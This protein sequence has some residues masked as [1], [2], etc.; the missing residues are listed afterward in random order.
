[1]YCTR[2][3][4]HN[5]GTNKFC[6]GCG[7]LLRN[8]TASVAPRLN[9]GLIAGIGAGTLVVVV[10]LA[11]VFLSSTTSTTNSPQAVVEAFYRAVIAGEY[12]KAKALTTPK[13]AEF[14]DSRP[15]LYW[16]VYTSDDDFSSKNGRMISATVTRVEQ[17]GE[18]A[19][20]CVRRAFETGYT[21]RHVVT[22]T[23]VNSRWLI[24][25]VSYFAYNCPR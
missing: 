24:D 19:A 7:G 5:P 16:E 22:L 3:G 11:V 12:S 21:S 20:V 9:Y 15:G 4:K 18:L 8:P 13:L 14:I 10:G 23:V 25:E 17:R 1:M 6:S 2:C